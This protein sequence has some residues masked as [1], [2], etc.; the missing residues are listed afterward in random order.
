MRS[1]VKSTGRFVLMMSTALSALCGTAAAQEQ[2]RAGASSGGF[3]EIIV[4]ARK[5]EENLQ[6][7]PDT[8]TAFS[9]SVIEERRLER[10]N[11]FLAVTPNVHITN[12]QDTATN[13]I[14][15]RGL[16][17]NRNQAKEGDTNVFMAEW[18]N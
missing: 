17:S 5:R 4:T 3:E 10:I 16:G 18:R 14:S 12:D 11:D 15:I 7:V 13:N 8:V 2:A 1:K 9:A 6:Q